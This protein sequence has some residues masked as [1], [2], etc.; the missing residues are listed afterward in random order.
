MTTAY[1]HIQP[2]LH[3]ATLKLSGTTETCMYDT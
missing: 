3:T 1:E 2:S